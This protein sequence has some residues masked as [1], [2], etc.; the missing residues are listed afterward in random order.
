ML[1]TLTGL[2]PAWRIGRRFPHRPNPIPFRRTA[3]F[4]KSAADVLLS[5]SKPPRA[6]RIT[7]PAD[8]FPNIRAILSQHFGA[9]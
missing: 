7:V 6:L 4:A 5:A 8:R 3:P 1:G 9:F 2:Y